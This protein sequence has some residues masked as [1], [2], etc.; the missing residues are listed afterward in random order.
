MKF[1]DVAVRVEQM[2][3]LILRQALTYLDS[4]ETLG[5]VYNS[6]NCSLTTFQIG[7]IINGHLCPLIMFLYIFQK[8]D[9]ATYKND[10]LCT[11]SV[12]ISHAF[13]IFFPRIISTILEKWHLI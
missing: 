8:G 2:R 10:S 6:I 9:V 3:Y 4:L 5:T 13:L 1:Y 11:F 7:S 12:V